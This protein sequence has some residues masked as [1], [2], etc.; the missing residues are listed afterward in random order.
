MSESFDR[1]EQIWSAAG[2]V[3]KFALALDDRDAERLSALFSADAHLITPDGEG[4]VGREAI[5]AHY[6]EAM[7]RVGATQHFLTNPVRT[8]E[9]GIERSYWYALIVIEE[10]RGSDRHHLLT[11]RYEFRIRVA[12]KPEITELRLHVQG[13]WR[14][15]R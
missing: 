6:R 8:V 14:L 13:R 5:H 12:E 3:Q 7:E 10:P 1:D 11:G 4:H 2:P 15:A 9:R